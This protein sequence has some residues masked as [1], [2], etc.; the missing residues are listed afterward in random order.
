MTNPSEHREALARIIK[1]KVS[2]P[3]FRDEAGYAAHYRD[4]DEAATAILAYLTASTRSGGRKCYECS[5]ELSGPI[6]LTC[7]PLAG[8]VE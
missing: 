3:M 2:G 8:S 5:S 6:C 4:I 7:N 1:E